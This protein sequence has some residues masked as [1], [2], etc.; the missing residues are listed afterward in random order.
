VDE[1]LGLLLELPPEGPGGAGVPL[2]PGYTH[3][4]AVSEDRVEELG[5]VR[6]S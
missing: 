2:T 6:R 3:V 5:K 1:G 4:S